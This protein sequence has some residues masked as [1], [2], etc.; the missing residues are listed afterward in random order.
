[1]TMVLTPY[2]ILA[3]EHDTPRDVIER[4]YARLSRRYHPGRYTH[5]EMPAEIAY[6]ARNMTRQIEQA[7]EAVCADSG[8]IAASA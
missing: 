1:M 8:E 4:Q 5:P 6:Y 2:K 3:I 7:Y